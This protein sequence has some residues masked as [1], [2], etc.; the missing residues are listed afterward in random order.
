VAE[1]DVEALEQR[2]GVRVVLVVR[3]QVVDEQQLLAGIDPR[4]ELARPVDVG[5][6]HHVVDLRLHEGQGE[7]VV[8][9]DGPLEGPTGRALGARP[10]GEPRHIWSQTLFTCV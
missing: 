1:T 9:R 2:L 10:S 3:P 5:E 7:A 4:G 8:V 6:P